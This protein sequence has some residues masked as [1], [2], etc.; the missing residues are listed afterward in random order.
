MRLYKRKPKVTDRGWLCVKGK[1]DNGFITCNAP[2]I[3]L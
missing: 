3:D 1:Y 2:K